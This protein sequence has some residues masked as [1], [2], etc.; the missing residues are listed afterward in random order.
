MSAVVNLSSDYQTQSNGQTERAN[1]SLE[2]PLRCVAAQ[3][4]A[5]WSLHLSWIE[6]AHNSLTCTAT[7]M[8]PFMACFV[9]QPPLFP[10][11]EMDMVVPSVRDHLRRIRE[12]WRN[13]RAVL[14]CTAERNKRLVDCHWSP[15][16]E[17]C[18]GQM[19]WLSSRNFPLQLDIRKCSPYFIGPFPIIKMPLCGQTEAPRLS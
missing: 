1:Q 14:T 8:S 2:N 5:S 13:V 6:D 15:A 18:P 17:Y 4:S 19:F 11:Q 12:V 10:Q 7:G 16:L 9:Y 3:H